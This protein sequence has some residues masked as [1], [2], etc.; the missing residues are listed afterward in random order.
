MENAFYCEPER[1]KC[2]LREKSS[3]TS[4]FCVGFFFDLLAV[5]LKIH[6]TTTLLYGEGEGRD[7]GGNMLLLF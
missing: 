6:I 7:E 4:F 5:Q 2:V 1:G 3:D